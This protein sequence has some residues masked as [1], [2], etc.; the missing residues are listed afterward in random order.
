MREELEKRLGSLQLELVEATAA[1]HRA[2][3]DLNSAKLRY[4]LG[5]LHLKLVEATDARHRAQRDLNSAKLR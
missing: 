5:S 3:R 4:E 2:Q 1:R